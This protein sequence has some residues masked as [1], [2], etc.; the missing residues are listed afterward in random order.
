ML[1]RP[2][3]NSVDEAPLRRQAKEGH[4]YVELK[5][6]DSATTVVTLGDED[7]LS[8]FSI[9]VPKG[10]SAELISNSLLTA[11]AGRIE[12]D[13]AAVSVEW[14]RRC[15]MSRP[16]QWQGDFERMLAYATS[17]GWMDPAGGAVMAH[18]ERV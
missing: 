10:S 8:R 5:G 7:D 9:R 6:V 1:S 16:A 17:K 14:L 11:G 15:T 4:V 3:I 18:I 13:H 2:S 12:G